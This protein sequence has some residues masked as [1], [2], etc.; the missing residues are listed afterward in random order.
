[1]EAEKN[2]LAK[3]EGTYPR[4]AALE[5]AGMAVEGKRYTG[6]GHKCR[7]CKSVIEAGQEAAVYEV[8]KAGSSQDSTIAVHIACISDTIKP[9]HTA[10]RAAHTGSTC[11]RCQGPVSD[12]SGFCG[13]C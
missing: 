4:Y 1:M 10:P 6:A 8:R 9:S 13:E 11:R 5:S 2:Y 12:G 3:L 7:C